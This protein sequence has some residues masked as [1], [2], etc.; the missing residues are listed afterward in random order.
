VDRWRDGIRNARGLLEVSVKATK[1][2]GLE[3]PP[4]EYKVVD[5]LTFDQDG[6]GR[7]SKKSF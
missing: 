7:M 2:E 4:S 6:V 3:N 5:Q 1:L